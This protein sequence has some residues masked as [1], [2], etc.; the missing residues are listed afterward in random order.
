[1][2]EKMG[3]QSV[4]LLILGLV[5]YSYAS[6]PICG[7]VDPEL[8][9]Q[10]RTVRDLA[11]N[12]LADEQNV[13]GSWPD[14]NT[15]NAILGLQLADQSWLA[16]Q[17]LG[18]RLLTR[19]RLEYEL[20]QYLLPWRSQCWR[21]LKDLELGGGRLGQ[22]ILALN[23]SCI[24]ADDFYGLNLNSLVVRLLKQFPEENFNNDF[25]YSLAILSLCSS[26]TNIFRK[27]LVRLA[28][29][30][31]ASRPCVSQ[32][33]LGDSGHSID[34][35]SMQVMAMVCARSQ[36]IDKNVPNWD[37]ILSTRVQCIIDDQNDDG[38]FGN[39]ITT[40]LAIQALT[41]ANASLTSWDCVDAV[42]FLLTQHT[43][44]NFGGVGST[45]QIIPILGCNNFGSLQNATITCPLLT[46]TPILPPIQPDDN[47][48]TFQVKV[49][50]NNETETYSVTILTGENL[51]YGMIRL[52]DVN[53]DFTFET[54]DS[55]FGQSVDAIN[56]VADDADNSLYWTIHI[57]QEGTYAASGIEGLYPSEE[58]VYLFILTDFS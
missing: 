14:V 38:S 56:G 9:E 2:Q 33:G 32:F 36:A 41:A 51:Y 20:M 8:D 28:R 16:G 26:E 24:S 27:A 31:D 15:Q 4:T 18:E 58:E 3:L 6:C 52:A 11:V 39:A 5:S 44:G 40:A 47:S 37:S 35:L 48:T 34:T 12:W 17:G 43:E 49:I 21:P 57:G 55:A 25:Q 13:D 42:E 46:A 19:A 7:G 29:G 23:A 45:A 54:S 1:M 53:S 30:F 50:V 10:L 22:Y